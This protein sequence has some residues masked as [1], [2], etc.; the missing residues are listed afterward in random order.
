MIFKVFMLKEH[1]F[2]AIEKASIKN[3]SE[4]SIGA[5][6]GT[7][8][9]VLREVLELHQGLSNFVRGIYGGWYK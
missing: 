6:T 5:G 7:V 3:I 1:V 8:A 2:K 9:L 4:G